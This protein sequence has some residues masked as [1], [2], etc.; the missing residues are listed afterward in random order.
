M[1]LAGRL[2]LLASAVVVMCF[3]SALYFNADLGV[4]T[5]DAVSLIISEKQNKVS[6]KFCWVISDTICVTLGVSLWLLGG[7]GWSGVQ[8]IAGI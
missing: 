3:G 1:G 2:L 8:A 5:Y 7:G 6:F 4:S